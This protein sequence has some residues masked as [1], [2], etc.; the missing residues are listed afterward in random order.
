MIINCRSDKEYEDTL[1][2]LA[3]INDLR[4][5][6]ADYCP[7]IEDDHP[8]IRTRLAKEVYL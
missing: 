8:W 1:R 7:P 3:V 6:A 5:R 4:R 2:L